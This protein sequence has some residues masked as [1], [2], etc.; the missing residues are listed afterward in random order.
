LYDQDEYGNFKLDEEGRS[1]TDGGIAAWLGEPLFKKA[2]VLFS[3]TR[4]MIET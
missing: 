3:R 1:V 2:A 4:L